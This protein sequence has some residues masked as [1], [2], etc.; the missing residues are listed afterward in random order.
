MK[1]IRTMLVGILGVFLVAGT[2]ATPVYARSFDTNTINK[3]G[4]TTVSQQASSNSA[5]T[6]LKGHG[7]VSSL[8]V[9][10]MAKEWN[11]VD[12][13][14]N[15][16]VL[17]QNGKLAN[18]WV[19]RGSR[20]YYFDP[21]THFMTRDQAKVIN[22]KEYFFDYDGVMISNCNVGNSY[23]GVD[24]AKAGAFN[25]KCS[26]VYKNV[27]FEGYKTISYQEFEQMV[28]S[29]KVKARVDYGYTGGSSN[30]SSSVTY[31]YAG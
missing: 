25:S 2:F 5:T 13:N 30:L 3:D 4:T 22:G 21:V 17:N 6:V 31:Y 23:Y 18:G 12:G 10:N 24:G 19:A 1:Q 7:I 16:I 27:T 14:P 20:W 15:K 26:G 9:T 29:G 28:N 11:I 8:D